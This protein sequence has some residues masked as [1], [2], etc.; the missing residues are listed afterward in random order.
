MM[1]RSTAVGAKWF[2][3]HS[4]DGRC[5]AAAAGTGTAPLTDH[6]PAADEVVDLPVGDVPLELL[7]RRRGIRPVETADR[8]DRCAAG[9]LV[10]CRVVRSHRSGRPRVV[11]RRRWPARRPGRGSELVRSAGPPGPICAN[12]W[13]VGPADG[14]APVC[15]LARRR[16]GVRGRRCQ[17]RRDGQPRHRTR[18]RGVQPTDHEQQHRSRHSPDRDNDPKPRQPAVGAGQQHARQDRADQNDARQRGRGAEARTGSA[19]TAL[20][21]CPPQ[22]RSQGPA[23]P[24]NTGARCRSCS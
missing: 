15:G 5:L 13:F 19:T 20:R 11:G 1:V 6:Q 4:R 22:R 18:N 23:P 14:I 21:R 24:C 7:Q 10:A 9:Q 3:T 2:S 16:N 17:A 8:H 12:P